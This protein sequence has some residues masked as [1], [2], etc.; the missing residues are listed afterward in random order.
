MVA[1]VVAVTVTAAVMVT[2]VVTG[3][4]GMS[5]MDTEVTVLSRRACMVA[6]TPNPFMFPR[7]NQ[8]S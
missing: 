1:F 5:V 7:Y 6:I 8:D 2:V 3:T 4:A